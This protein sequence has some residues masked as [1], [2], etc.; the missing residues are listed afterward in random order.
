MVHVTGQVTG[1]GILGGHG[2]GRGGR[3]V[4]PAVVMVLR[5]GGRRVHRHRVMVAGDVEA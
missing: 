5:Y 1:T 4:Q 3:V 2:P